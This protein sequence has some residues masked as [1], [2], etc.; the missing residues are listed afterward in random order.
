MY[1]NVVH[2]YKPS[3]AETAAAQLNGSIALFG[4]KNELESDGRHYGLEPL[5]RAK[6]KIPMPSRPSIG[7]LF[8]S[9][10]SVKASASIL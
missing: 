4:S 8:G 6:V 7:F 10:V 5:V 1:N 3:W 2:T 9:V